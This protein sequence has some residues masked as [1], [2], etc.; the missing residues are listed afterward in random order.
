MKATMK[1]ILSIG[2]ETI[3][4]VAI[5]AWTIPAVKSALITWVIRLGVPAGLATLAVTLGDAFVGKV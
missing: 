2:W 4:K 5:T 3:K 1:T